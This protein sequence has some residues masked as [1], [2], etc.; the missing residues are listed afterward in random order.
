[1]PQLVIKLP[2]FDIDVSEPEKFIAL[3]TKW[4]GG[5]F[6]LDGAENPIRVSGTSKTTHTREHHSVDNFM[7]EN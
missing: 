2:D 5:D 7:S 6:R 1:M 3:G 4:R